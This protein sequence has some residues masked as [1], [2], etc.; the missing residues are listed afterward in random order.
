[1]NDIVEQLRDWRKKMPANWYGNKDLDAAINEIK[2][3]REALEFYAE[4][5]NYSDDYWKGMWERARAA[6]DA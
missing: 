6:I 2:K 4:P 3:L 5:K 1:M